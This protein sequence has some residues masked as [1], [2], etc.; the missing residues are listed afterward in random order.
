MDT[1]SGIGKLDRERITALLRGTK[2]TISI[3]EATKIL[4]MSRENAA[5]RLARWA[6][7]GWL[8]RVKRGLYVPV[9]LESATKNIALEDPWIVADKLYQPCYIGG[10][11]AAE[12]WGLTEQIFRTIII[13][14]THKQKNHQPIIKGTRF[15][16]ITTSQ[17]KFFG[18]KTIWR[19]QTK[20]L[21]SDPSRTVLD[22][23]D[24]PKLGGGIRPVM[25][26]FKEYLASEH[27]NLN[28][29]LDYAIRINNGAVFKRLGFLLE[30][31]SPQEREM[32]EA[33]K[34]QLTKG[35]S[36]IDPQLKSDVLVTRWHLWIPK[37]WK[38]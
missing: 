1:P 17:E 20:V 33:C 5:K 22:L 35:N 18:L 10:W 28:L 26:I 31:Y 2:G 37:E 11:S 12:Y 7:K 38:E 32:I 19:G 25:D 29:L 21:V 15:L 13:K 23:L 36:K 34:A 14:T 4:G 27:N 3:D 8:L 16:L 30:R 24:E 6:S 9:P